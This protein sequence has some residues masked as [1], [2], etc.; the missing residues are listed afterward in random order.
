MRHVPFYFFIFYFFFISVPNYIPLRDLL[1][2][3]FFVIEQAWAVI[4]R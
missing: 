1:L 3:V 4:R 2:G